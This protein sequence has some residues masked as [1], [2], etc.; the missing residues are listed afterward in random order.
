MAWEQGGTAEPPGDAADRRGH[1]DA[2]LWV[3]ADDGLPQTYEV[4]GEPYADAAT[5][6]A[7]G[8]LSETHLSQ[9]IAQ[10]VSLTPGLRSHAPTV[11]AGLIPARSREGIKPSPTAL[12]VGCKVQTFM[13]MGAP[14]HRRMRYGLLDDKVGIVSVIRHAGCV[15]RC[16]DKGKIILALEERTERDISVNGFVKCRSDTALPFHKPA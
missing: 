10:K 2:V 14:P 3:P 11:G 16:H 1:A 6:R 5:D 8:D 4:C 13:P 12:G 15:L 9:G 7:G